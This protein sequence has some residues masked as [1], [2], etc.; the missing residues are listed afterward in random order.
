MNNTK[1]KTNKFKHAFISGNILI[2]IILFTLI[3]IRNQEF[4]LLDSNLTQSIYNS[5]KD[6]QLVIDINVFIT[7]YTLASVFG[8]AF[9]SLCLLIKKNFRTLYIFFVTA[10]ISLFVEELLKNIIHRTRPFLSISG[11]TNLSTQTLSL[12]DYSFPS[13]HSVFAFYIATFIALRIKRKLL[14]KVLIFMLATAVALSRIILGVHY[15]SDIIAGSS[16]GILLGFLSIYIEKR[17]LSS[18]KRLPDSSPNVS[19]NIV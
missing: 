17:L 16:I 1:T 10:L 18:S 2:C 13:A 7:T 6:N 8:F 19:E 3:I 15:V 9:V 12:S 11:I 5:F 4:L 14:L